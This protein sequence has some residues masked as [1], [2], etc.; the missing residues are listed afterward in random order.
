MS[1]LNTNTEE[2]IKT[3][4]RQI[5]FAEGRLNATTQEIAD[6]AGVNRTLLNYYFRSRDAL[7]D[8]VFDEAMQHLRHRIESSISSA[9]PFRE[10]METLVD[11]LLDEITQ[12][13]YR[14]IFI[15]TQINQKE[16]KLK[17]PTDKNNWPSFLAEIKKE[18]DAGTIPTMEPIDYILNIYSMCIFPILMKPIYSH[19]LRI[20]VDEYQE[21]LND[22]KA[23]IMAYVFPQNK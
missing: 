22:R 10:K 6:A 9:A 12:Y 17:P 20:T 18:M 13:P 16:N 3:V 8:Q 11:I 14:E 21:K 4:A 1:T 5:F 2:H 23:N 15:I 19:M 7:F